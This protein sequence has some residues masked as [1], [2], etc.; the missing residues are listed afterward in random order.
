MGLDN[1]EWI[2]KISARLNKRAE[3]EIV[4]SLDSLQE[5]LEA[6]YDRVELIV[7]SSAC[8]KCQQA[9]ARMGK[10]VLAEWLDSLQ[11]DAPLFEWTHPDD[12]T[13]TLKVYKHSDPTDAKFVYKNGDIK[14]A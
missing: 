8:E 13:C 9:K 10:R 12:G 3:H 14:D 4:M 2:N 11:H 7:L 6:G 5:L 1:S